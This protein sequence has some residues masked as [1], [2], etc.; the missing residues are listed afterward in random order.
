MSHSEGSRTEASGDYSHA[1]GMQTYAKGKSSHA[2]GETN[3]VEGNM[4]HVEGYSNEVYGDYAHAEGRN[5]LITAE[6]DYGHAEGS[7]TE[8]SNIA[9]HAEGSSTVASGKYSH[10]EGKGTVASGE[11][12][13]VQGRYNELDTN[14]SAGNYAFVIGNGTKENT[15]NEDGSI[16]NQYR[17]NA[18]TVDWNG[19]AR[20]AGDIFVGNNIRVIDENSA[21]GKR[22]Y[23]YDVYG[24][25]IGEIFNDYVNNKVLGVAHAEGSFAS[26]TGNFSHAEGFHTTTNNQSAH[27]EGEFTKAS[28]LASHAEGKGNDKTPTEASGEASHAEG[29]QT[30]ASGQNAHSEGRVTKA[31]GAKSHAEGW[32]TVASEDSQHVQGKYNEL[33]K[34]GSAGNYAHIVG[35]GSSKA[36]SNA[37][38]LDWSGNAW[39]AGDITIGKDAKKVATEVEIDELHKELSA[40]D[41][42]LDRLRTL[43]GD[44]IAHD[45]VIDGS[46]LKAWTEILPTQEG[47]GTPTK[48]NIRPFILYNQVVLNHSGKNFLNHLDIIESSGTPGSLDNAEITPDYVNIVR[49]SEYDYTKIP[50]YV[51]K[52]TP[53]TLWVEF[54]VYDRNEGEGRTTFDI[55]SNELF[56]GHKSTNI[57]ENGTYTICLNTI[58]PINGQ[59]LISFNANYGSIVPAKVKFR[60]MFV[61]GT[62]SKGTV[63]GFEP[64]NGHIYT[65]GILNDA[66]CGGTCYWNEGKIV[67]TYG[68]IES[69]AGE[70]VPEGWISSTGELSDGAQIVYPVKD[71][72]VITFTPQEIIAL[73]GTNYLYSHPGETSVKQDYVKIDRTLSQNGMAADAYVVGEAIRTIDE[74]IA[75]HAGVTTNNGGEI[76]NDYEN[77]KAFSPY[78]TANG[79]N[80]SAGSCGY[81]TL[82]IVVNTDANTAEITV[83]D[84]DLE[85]TNK[86]INTLAPTEEEPI[87]NISFDGTSH[88]VDTL[89]ITSLSSDTDGNTVITVGTVDGSEL[90]VLE[91]DGGEDASIAPA[92]SVEDWIWCSTRPNAGIIGGF[93]RGV[94]AGGDGAIAIGRGASSHGRETKAMG[95]YSHAEGRQT[96]AAYAAHAEGSRSKANGYYSHAEGSTTTANG[97]YSHAEGGQTVTNGKYSHA[98]GGNTIASGTTQHVQGKWN[99]EDTE[100]DANG[101]GRYAHIVGNGSNVARSNAHTLDW[102]GNAWFKGDVRIGG[103]S[104]DEG[105]ILATNEYVDSKDSATRNY[106]DKKR[107]TAGKKNGTSLGAAATAEGYDTTASG[108]YSH[109]E[110]EGTEATGRAAHAEGSNTKAK[111]TYTHAE[112]AGTEA[113]GSWDHS[114]GYKS[115]ASGSA[116]HAEGYSTVASGLR[117]HAE[118]NGT[119]AAGD[120]QHVQGRFNIV[121]TGTNSVSPNK[122]GKYLH[123]V[124]NGKSDT[125]RS[126]A[127]RLDWDGNAWFAGSV[128]STGIKSNGNIEFGNTSNYLSWTTNDNT[129]IHMRPYAP[130]NVFQI[131]MQN[132][133]AGITEYGALSIHTNGKIELGGPL[134]TQGLVLKYKETYGS[135]ADMYSIA[136][137]VEGQIFFVE[138]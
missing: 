4:S 36:R 53:Y 96:F 110:G 101:Y 107:V 82:S 48:E 122:K 117:S 31:I 97:D 83:K 38:T 81:K 32:N 115:V 84:K 79:Y 128:E 42:V 40:Q 56:G 87:V 98:E 58:S 78:S 7:G 6:G 108:G 93:S 94:S 90:P 39:Y 134:Y 114:E 49:K 91:M 121:D 20:F 17:S 65:T 123:I 19:T 126:D 100:I 37:H 103:V 41:M 106:I 22:K 55:A 10:A 64:Y 109:A 86:A 33:D 104:Y 59:T 138:A 127:H 129:Q 44:I 95:H 133:G 137:P 102:K 74:T 51:E 2:E 46:I 47:E 75:L 118:G 60:A 3:L 61:E 116:S 57:Q 112:G 131:T 77:N 52:G 71:G 15:Y 76:F 12:Q 50:V 125:Q 27:A 89:K 135:E 21:V 92:E 70:E 28:G 136:N 26:A 24:N 23:S 80:S 16:K 132:P 124:G 99:I 67:P 85:E 54:E 1:E 66:F 43:T 14:R 63:P 62:Y 45:N 18:M 72:E 35:N 25:L 34:N 113:L 30:L 120:I 8:V 130:T 119:V 68:Y 9:G 29:Y 105:Q 11:A 13:H 69:Y 88:Y 111:N 73:S 5:I